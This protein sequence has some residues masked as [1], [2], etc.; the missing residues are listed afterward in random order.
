MPRRGGIR[1]GMVSDLKAPSSEP[2][3]QSGA[4]RYLYLQETV[5]T[6]MLQSLTLPAVAQSR[7]EKVQEPMSQSFCVGLISKITDDMIVE[8]SLLIK[9]PAL[10]TVGVSIN[11]GIHLRS[12]TG[13]SSTPGAN[14]EETGL[15]A[16]AKPTDWEVGGKEIKRSKPS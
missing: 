9:F 10:E 3:N 5:A 14:C 4:N 16:D 6:E 1:P 12:S 8:N 13:P 11:L 15:T 2:A 7:H